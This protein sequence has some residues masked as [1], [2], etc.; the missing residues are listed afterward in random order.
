VA[1]HSHSP[2]GHLVSLF[3]GHASRESL[4]AELT[5]MLKEAGFSDVEVIPTRHKNFA[6]LRAR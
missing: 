5:P 3:G 6:V 2:L 4:V 1:A